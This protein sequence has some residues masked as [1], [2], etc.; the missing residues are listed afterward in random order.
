MSSDITPCGQASIHFLQA[1][2]RS[3]LTLMALVFSFFDKALSGQTLI[4]G[5]GSH[6]VQIIGILTPV[7]SFLLILTLVLA[8]LITP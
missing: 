2:Q 7:S 6:C 4:Q 5:A 8:G 1:T 3:S